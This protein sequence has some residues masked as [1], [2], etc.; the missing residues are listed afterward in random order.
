MADSYLGAIVA[1]PFDYPPHGWAFCNGQL[2]PIQ[3]Y[4]ALF[5]LLGT[6]YGGNGQTT[7]QL[8][9]LQSRVPI[10]Q[11]QEFQLGEIGGTEA[12][13]LTIPEI[14]AHQHAVTRTASKDKETTNRPDGAYF[15]AGGSYAGSTNGAAM[16]P[17]ATSNVGG[18]QPHTN[19]QPYLALRYIIALIGI[20]PTRS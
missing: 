12:H 19:L 4:T 9:N 5:S 2:L 1:V 14:A 6:T 3:Q 17:T 7:F 11:S 15:T 10:H 8:P 20:Y 18:N 16:G 13:T